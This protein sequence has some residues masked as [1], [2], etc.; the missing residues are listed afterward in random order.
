MEIFAHVVGEHQIDNPLRLVIHLATSWFMILAVPFL[1]G[2][3]SAYFIIKNKL[4]V[5]RQE[6]RKE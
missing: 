6:K 4:K 1:I 3:C 2:V 5:A